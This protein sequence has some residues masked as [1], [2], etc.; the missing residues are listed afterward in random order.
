M[1]KGSKHSEEAKAKLSAAGMGRKF[2]EERKA[3]ISQSM[4]GKPKSEE[5]KE[6]LRAANIGKKH[7]AESRAKMS[8]DRKREG[9][10]LWKGGRIVK[11]DGRI[12]IHSPDHPCCGATG[13]VSEHRLVMET[14]L[15]RFLEPAETVHHIDHNPSNNSPNNLR[16][17]HSVGAH[18]AYH[19]ELRWRAAEARR[20]CSDYQVQSSD[21]QQA[22]RDPRGEVPVGCLCLTGLEGRP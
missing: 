18:T 9:T 17:F 14:L 1:L 2:S 10:H 21:T 16:L 22:S 8:A 13:Y 15:G 19:A 7:T 20:K 4:K 3:K 12:Q 11:G 5:C 6:K